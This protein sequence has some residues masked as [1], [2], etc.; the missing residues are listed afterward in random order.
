MTI[1][2]LDSLSTTVA[3][4]RTGLSVDDDVDRFFLLNDCC[5]GNFFVADGKSMY[6][7]CRLSLP[8]AAKEAISNTSCTLALFVL[9]EHSTYAAALI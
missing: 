5:S 1:H 8:M 7:F 4:T 9:D 3:F 2:P 6:D